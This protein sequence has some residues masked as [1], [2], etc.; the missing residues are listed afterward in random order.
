[1]MLSSAALAP[2]AIRPRA[3]GATSNC[4]K[5]FISSSHRK[6]AQQRQ[7]S[8]SHFSEAF[9]ARDVTQGHTSSIKNYTTSQKALYSLHISQQNTGHCWAQQCD[10]NS[11]GSSL[12]MLE[13]FNQSRPTHRS[14]RRLERISLTDFTREFTAYQ[15]LIWI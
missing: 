11:Q 7:T 2:E 13:V 10:K 9:T 12:K 4:W 3:A 14:I 15:A 6:W 8:I 1:L 5:S